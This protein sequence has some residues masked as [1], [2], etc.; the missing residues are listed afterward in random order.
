MTSVYSDDY[1]SVISALKQ[2]RVRRNITQTAIATALGRPQSFIAKVEN[3]ERRL[4]VVEF[5][6]LAQLLGM[7]WQ[8][9]LQSIARKYV[10]L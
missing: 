4:D 5:I 6:R 1:Q 9:E 2:A 8:S 3:G 7:D 10:P